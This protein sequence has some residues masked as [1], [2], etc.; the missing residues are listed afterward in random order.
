MLKDKI[1]F[2]SGSSRGIG[3]EIVKVFAENHG[4]VYA[5]IRT[6]G[7]LNEW[8]DQMPPSVKEQIIPI[9]FDI[10]DSSALRNAVLDI[11]RKSG[12]IDVWVN[13]AAVVYNEAIGMISPDHIHQMFETN[14]YPVIDSIQL[15]S[16]LMRRQRSGSIINISSMVG[17][18]GDAGQMAYSATKGAVIS[19]TKSAAKELAP[20]QVRVNS[21][22]PGLTK[23]DLLDET[24]DK[25]LAQRIAN[26][27]MGRVASPLDIANTCL[28][29]ASELSVYVT[30]QIIGVDGSSII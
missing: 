28:F 8:M 17:L 18:K 25:F 27:G 7:S 30:G 9:T 4:T 2:V 24:E 20:Y 16:R 6:E 14:V 21:V 12:G 26:I 10:R 5:N 29:L 3:K 15:V 13:N 11:K 19:I 23:T 1:C 22:A